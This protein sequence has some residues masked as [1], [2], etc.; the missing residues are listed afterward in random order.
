LSQE[1][2]RTVDLH[3][4]TAVTY[5]AGPLVD[6]SSRTFSAGGV[7][8]MRVS[9]E[10]VAAF[11]RQH[12]VAPRNVLVGENPL[13]NCSDPWVRAH[14]LGVVCHLEEV[15]HLGGREGA[16]PTSVA[17][18]LRA[19]H[20]VPSGQVS[21][22]TT[23]VAELPSAWPHK[24]FQ[25]RPLAESAKAILV[26]A[27]DGEGYVLWEPKQAPSPPPGSTSTRND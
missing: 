20:S 3:G 15:Y 23:W 10:I 11:V 21:V 7:A 26:S 27:F 17:G 25:L 4:G 2:I 16:G 19:A 9:E 12:I 5:L 14:P 13:A 22:I 8:N 24:I 18:A 1:V 6:L